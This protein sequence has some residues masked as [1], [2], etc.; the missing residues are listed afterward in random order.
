MTEKNNT[1]PKPIDPLI[2]QAIEAIRSTAVPPMPLRVQAAT[3]AKMESA[4]RQSRLALLYEGIK[5]M[6]K[7]IKYPAAVAAGILLLIA[8]KAFIAAGSAGPKAAW[9]D[10]TANIRNAKIMVFWQYVTVT[11]PDGIHRR[12]T[13]RNYIKSP[14]A[15]RVE[16]WPTTRPSS[17]PATSSAAFTSLA[18]LNIPD[19]QDHLCTMMKSPGNWERWVY[20]GPNRPVQDAQRPDMFRNVLQSI[21]DKDALRVGQDVIDGVKT[22]RFEA[23]ISPDIVRSLDMP[24]GSSGTIQVWVAEASGLPVRVRAAGS[25]QVGSAPKREFEALADKIEWDVPIPDSLFQ[26]P[27]NN[28]IQIRE[29]WQVDC[30]EYVSRDQFTFRAWVEGQPPSF[31][32]EDGDIPVSKSLDGTR[33]ESTEGITFTLRNG[34]LRDLTSQHVGDVLVMEIAGKWTFKRKI[35]YPISYLVV[36]C[37]A[38]SNAN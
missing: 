27:N 9:A 34:P 3:V 35:E 23:A 14:S 15:M 25:I 22:T 18:L 32:E 5:N 17:T 26:I 30:P 16:T 29:C 20:I 12:Q 6:N 1:L 4:A 8:V 24:L 13:L 31:S 21:Q 19:G 28:D 36:I 38:P 2:G 37:P 33:N 7:F 11:G 10:V